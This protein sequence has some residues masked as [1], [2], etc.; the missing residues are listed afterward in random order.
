[1]SRITNKTTRLGIAA[2]TALLAGQ[3]VAQPITPT[4]TTVVS[5]CTTVGNQFSTGGSFYWDV[6]AGC[7]IYQNDVY[8]RPTNQTY[9][10]RGTRFAANEYFEFI[11]IEEVR[12]GSDARFL[13]VSINLVGR[14]NRTSV[15]DSIPVG[16]F[17]QY[18]FRI[19]TDVDGRFGH[20][21]ISDQPEVRANP[22]GIYTASG[23]FGYVDTNGDVGGGASSGPTGL[24]VTKSD[25]PAE[26][27]MNGYDSAII[28][29]GVLQGA[30]TVLWARINPADN[31]TVELALDYVALGLTPADIANLR[32]FDVDAVQGG[33][34][35]G[36]DCLWND[37][38]EGPE[39]GSPNLGANG[40]S[41]FGTNGLGGI[42]GVD[43]VRIAG[44]GGPPP[45]PPV[46]RPDIDGNGFVNTSDV[47]AYITIF[48][49]N[50]PLA[51][52]NADGVINSAD[53]F[54]FF[55][56]WFMGCP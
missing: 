21:F 34:S 55:A 20:R 33:P 47:F 40:Q 56:E 6:T 49:G 42:S 30:T 31:T 4:Y 19:S 46:C 11:D 35:S 5:D 39:A 16:L 44:A 53:F 9:E 28:S 10:L 45:P 13:Y 32:Y 41:E 3:A 54:A 15:G 23:T 18:G 29:D 12:V 50:D 14:N 38:F 24:N 51:D 43:T 37:K 22:A 8:E 7:D 48:F 17:S 52:Y 25:N 26:A 1:M 2:A 36:S 27:S